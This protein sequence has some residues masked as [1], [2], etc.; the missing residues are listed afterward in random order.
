LLKK[1]GTAGLIDVAYLDEAGFAMT[2]PVCYSWFPIGERLCIPYEAPQ[3]RRVNAIGA[4]FSD[5][6]LAGRFVYQTWASLPPH[7][8]NAKRKTAEQVAHDYGLTLDE[9][10]PIDAVRLLAFF[11]HIADRPADAGADWK[12]ERP[13][14]IVL[15]NYSVHKSQTI[16]EA[17]VALEAADIF[18]VYL[19]SYSPE[20]SKIE[21]IWN[22]V[23]H[24]YLTKR[25]YEQV[26]DL[27][28]ATD[29]ALADK[30]AD[31]LKQHESAAEAERVALNLLN[32]SGLE[33]SASEATDLVPTV[34][35]SKKPPPDVGKRRH[36]QPETTNIQRMAA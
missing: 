19:P 20:L 15:D 11:W 13:L 9:I 1:R 32:I 16:Q 25:S 6:P 26:D 18:L 8:R 5:G 33:V 12:R 27:K 31:L 21:P 10:G 29:T 22:D 4:Y 23:K 30:A 3:G 24:H 28:R 7:A 34:K 36:P 35:R 2:L 14:M 17:V